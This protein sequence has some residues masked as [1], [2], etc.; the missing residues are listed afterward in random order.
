MI[1]TYSQITDAAGNV[2]SAWTA[3]QQSANCG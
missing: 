1:Q 2:Y 3:N